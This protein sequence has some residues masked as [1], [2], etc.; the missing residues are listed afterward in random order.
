MSL[1]IPSTPEL[2]L[3]ESL[4]QLAGGAGVK[5]PTAMRPE[6]QFRVA[7]EIA[8]VILSLGFGND[9]DLRSLGGHSQTHK[10]LSV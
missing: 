8:P 7:G 6:V 2:Q 9:G 1:R 4:E 10:G 5:E 3:T